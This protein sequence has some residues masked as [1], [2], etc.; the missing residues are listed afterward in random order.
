M[1][2]PHQNSLNN[3][4]ELII[5][6]DGFCPLCIKEMNHI[7]SRD[8]HNR[9]QLINLQ[10]EHD[11]KCHPELDTEKA[12]K[13]LQGKRKDGSYIEGLDVTHMAWSLLGKG[14]LTYILRVPFL[15]IMFD[16]FY[17]MFAKHRYTFSFWL[18]GQRYGC[19]TCK[20]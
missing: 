6:Y 12:M 9:I 2:T 7:R 19:E 8:K 16:F 10:S 1:K 14:H 4:P 5:F 20:K 18:T 15:R 3:Q 13:I 17:K 11:I